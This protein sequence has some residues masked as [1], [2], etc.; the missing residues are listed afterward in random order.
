[1]WLCPRMV[2]PSLGRSCPRAGRCE[3]TGGGSRTEAVAPQRHV[4]TRDDHGDVSSHPSGI[5]EP[6]S[7]TGPGG[8]R[9]AAARPKISL[10]GQ[11]LG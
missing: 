10:E 11:R 3:A 6:I 2:S 9:G 7:D 5:S 8:A 4:V 1:M